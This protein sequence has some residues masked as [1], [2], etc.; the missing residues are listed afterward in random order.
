M[1]FGQF[2]LIEV[3]EVN[4]EWFTGCVED[5]KMGKKSNGIFPSNYVVK[6][7]FSDELILKNNFGITLVEYNA[8]TNEELNLIPNEF[9]SIDQ[10]SEDLQWTLVEKYVN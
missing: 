9:V 7:N 10:V 5:T 8:L 1:N 3:L 4:G 2:E 6:F